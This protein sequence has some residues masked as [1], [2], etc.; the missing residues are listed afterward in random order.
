MLSRAWREPRRRGDH[1]CAGAELAR[2]T[3]AIAEIAKTL[4]RLVDNGHVDDRP[5][6]PIIEGFV[7]ANGRIDAAPPTEGWKLGVAAV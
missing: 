2:R 4:K 5:D 6:R 1:V 3:A 7:G